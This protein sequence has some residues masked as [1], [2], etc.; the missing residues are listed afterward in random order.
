MLQTVSTSSDKCRY[1]RGPARRLDY[2]LIRQRLEAG[3]HNSDLAAEYGVSCSVISRCAYRAG[4]RWQ[5]GLRSVK[6]RPTW[7]A[8]EQKRQEIV[9]LVAVGFSQTLVA[10]EY[11]L[12]R[13]RVSMIVCESRRALQ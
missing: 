11:G 5:R 7:K 9:S 12:S 1:A 13:S 10:M 6:R 8:D 3:E 4:Y 2:A